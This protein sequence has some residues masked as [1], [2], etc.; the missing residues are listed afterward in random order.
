MSK[1]SWRLA[2]G[3]R[4][5]FNDEVY[6]QL[7]SVLGNL[8]SQNERS[9]DVRLIVREI[10]DNVA[11]YGVQKGTQNVSLEIKKIETNKV[12]VK[13]T[14][15]GPHFDPFDEE[16]DCSFIK[17]IKERLRIKIK[18]HLGDSAPRYNIHIEV[19]I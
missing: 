1:R 13:I 14:H 8:Y 4:G 2:P 15:D 11:K 9:K 5:T 3:N 6:A 12:E 19:D 18:I 7:D 16:S 10:M 17:S